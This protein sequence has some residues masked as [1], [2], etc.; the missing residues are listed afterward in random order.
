L[1]DLMFFRRFGNEESINRFSYYLLLTISFASVVN[2]YYE[3]TSRY[4]LLFLLFCSK[5]INI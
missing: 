5:N 2:V 4:G 1:I 3:Y